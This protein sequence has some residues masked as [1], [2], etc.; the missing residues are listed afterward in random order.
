MNNFIN[1]DEDFK[2]QFNTWKNNNGMKYIV[3]KGENGHEERVS[4]DAVL[5][6]LNSM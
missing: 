5:D 6:A 4:L 2:D 1:G 3:V